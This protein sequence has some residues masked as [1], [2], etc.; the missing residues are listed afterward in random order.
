MSMHPLSLNLRAALLGSVLILILGPSQAADAPPGNATPL[1]GMAAAFGPVAPADLAKA[2]AASPAPTPPT[3]DPAYKAIHNL[4]AAQAEGYEAAMRKTWDFKEY[5]TVPMLRPAESAA[6]A[7][8]YIAL[9]DKTRGDCATA[10]LTCVQ[11]LQPGF[12]E[13]LPGIDLYRLQKPDARAVAHA[14]LEAIRDLGQPDNELPLPIRVL[15]G[16]G[17]YPP[18]AWRPDNSVVQ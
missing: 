1:N 11:L 8:D 3:D 9:L 5:V 2:A 17:N 18:S 7:Q 6:F 4:F 12:G 10:Q 16:F 14:W 13:I 15:D